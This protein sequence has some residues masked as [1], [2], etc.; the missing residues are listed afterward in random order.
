M[1]LGRPRLHL[2][3]TASTNDV[4]KELAGGGAAHGTLVTAGVQ[5]A[6]RGRRGRSWYAAPGEALLMSLVL[7]EATELLP[8]AAAIAA[9]EAIGPGAM[10]KWPNDILVDGRKVAGILIERR[11]HEDWTVL[12]IG[13]NVALTAFPPDLTESAG[14]L[15]RTPRDV[16]PLLASVLR[17]LERTLAASPAG[18][19]RAW[20]A[21][22]ALRDRQ[23]TWPDGDGVAAGIDAQGRLLV[24]RG[25]G[26]VAS[27][28]A[29]EVA[30]SQD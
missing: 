27:L 3:S 30:L 14:S 29:G 26:T 23:V 19:S 15:G 20:E 11:P 9:A 7:R 24:T 8:I 28:D 2:R 21:R 13:V 1:S 18:L 16:E 5:T 17:E 12:G 10:I 6:G 25:D 4:A 22:D